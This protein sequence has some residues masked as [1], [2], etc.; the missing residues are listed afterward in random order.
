VTNK[1][2]RKEWGT[3][4]QT[5]GKGLGRRHDLFKPLRPHRVFSLSVVARIKAT[6]LP[7]RGRVQR[8]KFHK[9][10]GQ[11]DPSTLQLWI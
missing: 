5:P 10:E 9:N 4:K 11:N 6:V 8:T 3:D 2:Q 7:P 1:G